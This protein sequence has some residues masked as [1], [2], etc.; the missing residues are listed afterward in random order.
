MNKLILWLVFLIGTASGLFAAG[1]EEKMVDIYY[2]ASLNGN[3]DGC[4]CKGNPRSGLV[5]RAVFLRGIDRNKSLILETGDI[6]DVYPDELLSD[7]ILQS[8]RDLGYDAI[9]VGD[10]EFSNGT[11]Y[12]FDRLLDFP[13]LSN[14]LFIQNGSGALTEISKSPLVFPKKGLDI[15]IVSIT[16]PEVFRFYPESIRQGIK[17]ENPAESIFKLLN[18]KVSKNS[19]LRI[20][21]FHGSLKKAREL[22]E[23]NPSLNII[24]AGH[25][26]QIADGE[27]IGNTILVSPG[28]DGN[29][30]GHLRVSANG[31]KILYT[32]EFIKFDYMK[33]PDD[34]FIRKKIE[35]YNAIMTERLNTN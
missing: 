16:D 15:A 17:A 2:S 28:A 31:Q 27:M 5:K 33:D 4:K 18:R 30:L 24:I 8:Y 20:L 9:A 1:A 22:A 14:N 11:A 23:M 19:D 29:L 7:Y 3:L 26:Q 35:K 13:F 6:F 10:Q 12:L 34:P 21:L 25:E 32:N